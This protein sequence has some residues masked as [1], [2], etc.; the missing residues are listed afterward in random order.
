[1]GSNNITN[2]SE[3]FDARLAPI[4]MGTNK[5]TPVSTAMITLYVSLGVV[6]VMVLVLVIVLMNRRRKKKFTDASMSYSM[7]S[8]TS[9]AI[10]PNSSINELRQ[11]EREIQ[12]QHLKKQRKEIEYIIKAQA[13][14]GERRKK[15]TA[16]KNKTFYV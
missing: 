1:M 14:K 5:A 15:R 10:N 6:I 11:M 2:L 3:V 4:T 9:T 12:R 16:D 7:G 8:T 13:K